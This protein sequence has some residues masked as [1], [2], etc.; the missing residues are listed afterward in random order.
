[1]PCRVSCENRES[2]S[3]LDRAREVSRPGRDHR[4]SCSHL[5]ILGIVCFFVEPMGVRV[6]AVAVTLADRVSFSRCE[7]LT[8]QALNHLGLTSAVDIKTHGLLPY[9]AG[10]DESGVNISLPSCFSIRDLTF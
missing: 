8:Q 4:A 3:A 7:A 5:I 10:R 6:D 2:I 1:M 9:G